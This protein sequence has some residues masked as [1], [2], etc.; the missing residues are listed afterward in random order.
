MLHGLF[1]EQGVTTITKKDL[2]KDEA[3]RASILQLSGVYRTMGSQDGTL[4]TAIDEQIVFVN[5]QIHEMLCARQDEAKI[6]MS[7]LGVGPVAALT[8]LGF[9]GNGDRFANAS[10]V[11]YYAGLVPR[12]DFSGDS[13]HHVGHITKKGS[14][15]L[16]RALVQAAWSAVRTPMG[17]HFREVYDRIAARRGKRIAI[18]AVARRILELMYT[19]MRKHELYRYCTQEQ[20]QR[21]LKLYK[22]APL[23]SGTVLKSMIESPHAEE[24]GSRV[25]QLPIGCVNSCISS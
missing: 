2:A 21:K 18:V 8:F 9:I 7:I 16:R 17:S 1:V 6:L 19:L 23:Q 22:L 4:L 25:W 14:P 10:Q 13:V 3:R 12:V 5:A 20:R 15:A 11:S 24:K